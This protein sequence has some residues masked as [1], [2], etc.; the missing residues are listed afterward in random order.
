MIKTNPVNNMYKINYSCL[1]F[2][3]GN[4][5]TEDVKHIS[6]IEESMK[7]GDFIPPI[8][9]DEKTLTIIDGQHRYLAAC[10][11]WKKGGNYD[12]NIILDNF[13]NP[14]LA[15][16]NY[17]GSSKKWNT[18]DYI[19]AYIEDGRKSFELLKTFCD[20]HSLFKNS[21]QGRV[22]YKG[23]AQ[24]LTGLVCDRTIPKGTLTITEE[25]ISDG[26][27]TYQQLKTL[28]EATGCKSLVSRSHVLAWIETRDYILYKMPLQ[29]FVTLM[30]NYFV[31]PVIS[32]KKEWVTEYLRVASKL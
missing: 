21:N 24:M 10:N 20:T 25:Q 32:S 5:Q 8:L 16:I 18:E 17:N 28:V 3:S 11:I 14:L 2:V 27:I 13:D 12:L 7:R 1:K 6:N 19:D 26:E 31:A 22:N 15:A 29:K 23:A 4:R 30:K 9:V